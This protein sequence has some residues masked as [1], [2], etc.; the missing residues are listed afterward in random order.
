MSRLSLAIL[1]AMIVLAAPA[2]AHA[3]PRAFT[4]SFD[5][6]DTARW[7][8][9]EHQLGLRELRLGS[10]SELNVP[11]FNKT[12]SLLANLDGI[13][14]AKLERPDEC[15]GFGGSFAIYE[16]GVS[17][18]MGRDRIADHER[19]GAEV[20]TA[21]DM[22]CLMHL[23]GLIRRDRTPLRVMHIAELLVEAI[24][25]RGEKESTTETQRPG[26]GVTG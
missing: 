14:F 11:P 15:C 25:A 16:E 1:V 6:F 23:E 10:D 20:L 2:Q 19:G 9:G 26:V 24:R 21:G 17:C 3:A 18:M 8:V 5:S 7:R 4:D 12:E 13:E 22:S